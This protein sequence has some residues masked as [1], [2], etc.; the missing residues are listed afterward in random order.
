MSGVSLGAFAVN[1]S[2]NDLAGALMLV[3]V[4]HLAVI[5][6]AKDTVNLIF[7]R[8]CDVALL[9]AIAAI[10]TS[11]QSATLVTVGF[12]GFLALGTAITVRAKRHDSFVLTIGA[13]VITSVILGQVFPEVAI[14]SLTQAGLSL[15][16]LIPLLLLLF[17]A[18]IRSLPRVWSDAVKTGI[19]ALQV[20]SVVFA[21]VHGEYS[22]LLFST[23]AALVSIAIS[24]GLRAK[25]WVE[26]AVAFTLAPFGYVVFAL[27]DDYLRDL[28]LFTCSVVVALIINISIALIYKL[29]SARWVSSAGWLA[30]PFALGIE[31]IGAFDLEPVQQMWLYLASAVAIG[32]K[33]CLTSEHGK[34]KQLIV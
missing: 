27:S 20:L 11:V 2:L 1:E 10:L 33:R 24:E 13:W 28:P 5:A 12:M 17:D 31:K 25:E 4:V 15:V 21:Y 18:N 8:F 26:V 23:I 34:R 9:V 30:L 6:L 19:I 22:V 3:G 29:E 16:F 7:T 32:F 14:S